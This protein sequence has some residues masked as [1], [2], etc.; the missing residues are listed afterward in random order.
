MYALVATGFIF[1]LIFAKRQ[2][3]YRFNKLFIPTICLLAL[4]SIIYMVQLT[5]A[6]EPAYYYFKLMSV[7]MIIVL[8]LALVGYGLGLEKLKGRLKLATALPALVVLLL[9]LI[10]QLTEKPSLMYLVSFRDAS[11]QLG[12]SIY[13][14]LQQSP[15]GNYWDKSYTFY[16]IPAKPFQN[17]F[18]TTLAKVDKPNSGCFNTTRAVLDF[19][20]DYQGGASDIKRD[21]KGKYSLRIITTPDRVKE[22]TTITNKRGLASTVTIIAQPNL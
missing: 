1:G 14:Q 19:K 3:V 22:L 11:K 16:Y 10:P 5:H 21:C 20:G 13:S 6:R 9:L 4:A 2:A 7:I 8:P 18:G 15:I 17:D 12:D